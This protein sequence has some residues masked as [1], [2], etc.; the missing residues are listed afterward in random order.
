M[1]AIII[2]G[3]EA[4][5]KKSKSI[6]I[7]IIHHSSICWLIEKLFIPT[8]TRQSNRIRMDYICELDSRLVLKKNK[9]NG[10]E[11][12]VIVLSLKWR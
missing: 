2:P 9:P 6:K 10:N 4:N 8:Q 3:A 7:E 5:M 1:F 11:L 12:K